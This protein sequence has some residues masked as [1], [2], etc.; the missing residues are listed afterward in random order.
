MKSTL[1]IILLVFTTFNLNSVSIQK[2]R[3]IH[4]TTLG[5]VDINYV[6]FI[7]SSIESFYGFKCLITP[8]QDIS[9]DILTES[10]QKLDA[11]KILKKFKNENHI[12]IITEKDI[13]HKRGS[14][15]EYGIIGLG[16]CPG[17]TCVISTH[18]IKSKTNEKNFY[19]RFK[20]V[21]LHEIGHNLGIPH[22]VSNKKCLM[23]DA[24]GTVK[25]IDKED[26]TIC[27]DCRKKIK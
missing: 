9:E 21:C 25:T 14:I 5:K 27:G 26:V 19:D 8:S 3:L 18:R 2:Q 10:K 17:K 1:I 13:S 20:K 11:P 6:K 15:S 22:C 16:Y 12:L 23:N 7:K 24:K 4:I